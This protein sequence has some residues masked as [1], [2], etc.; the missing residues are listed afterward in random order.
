M[1]RRGEMGRSAPVTV[2][3][4][5]WLCGTGSLIIRLKTG[6]NASFYSLIIA[7]QT[8]VRYLEENCVGSTMK[9][10][11]EKVVKNLPVPNYTVQQQRD[12]VEIL[13]SIFAKEQQAKD[14]ARQVIDQIDTMKKAILARAFRGELGTNDPTEESAEGLLKAN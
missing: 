4:E 12:I 7:S 8:S 13:N 9:N 5:G 14:I 3:E 10:L 1:G 11:N 2:K 6:Y